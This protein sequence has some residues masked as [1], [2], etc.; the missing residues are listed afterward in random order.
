MV[1][2]AYSE[3]TMSNPGMEKAFV[4][5]D[6]IQSSVTKRKLCEDVNYIYGYN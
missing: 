4:K 2:Y 1:S 3:Q 5:R 6:Q